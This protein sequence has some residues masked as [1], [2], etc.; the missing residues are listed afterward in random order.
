[1]D[2][3][4]CNR[5]SVARVQVVSLSADGG[6]L[7]AR[8]SITPS[9]DGGKIDWVAAAP[10]ERRSSETGSC[11]PFANEQMAFEGSSAM[12]GSSRAELGEGEDGGPVFTIRLRAIPN[13]FYS[14][15][16]TQRVPPAVFVFYKHEGRPIRG[17]A[18]VADGVPFRSLT[19]PAI[20]PDAASSMYDV[21]P[22]AARS[23]ADILFA[24]AFPRAPLP[25]SLASANPSTPI[26][27]WGGK[28]PV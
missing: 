1:M 18:K 13:A 3:D 22:V 12:R 5:G 23:Q 17:S 4:R 8:L 14:G 26:A 27:F 28:P 6:S 10:P 24:S 9:P 2:D 19:Y 21:P 7:T 20:R 15:M 25:L 16:G 11:L